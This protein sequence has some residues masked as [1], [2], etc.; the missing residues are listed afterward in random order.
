MRRTPD[1]EETVA[2]GTTDRAHAEAEPVVVGHPGAKHF[3]LE[4]SFQSAKANPS[5]PSKNIPHVE[6]AAHFI[7]FIYTE[8]TAETLN[9]YCESSVSI[10]DTRIPSRVQTFFCSKEHCTD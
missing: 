8:V 5:T 9:K 1:R 7:L 4:I 10:C 3:L 2:P 6:L